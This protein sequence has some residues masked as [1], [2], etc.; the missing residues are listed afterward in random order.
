MTARVL[1][2]SVIA[3]SALIFGAAIAN[4]QTNPPTTQSPAA[5]PA[6]PPT[7]AAPP[8]H[9]SSATTPTTR[10]P[11][12]ATSPSQSSERSATPGQPGRAEP[13]TTTQ[14]TSTRN[15][16]PSGAGSG[17][18]SQTAAPST[19]S[20]SHAAT[21]PAVNL[22]TQQRTEIRNTVINTGSAPRVASVNFN[23][24]VGVV[25]PTT[26]HF[27][28]VPEALVRI[29]PAW[30]GFDYFVYADEIIIV[31]PRTRRIIAVLA[32]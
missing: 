17:S 9:S 13:G 6:N 28:P 21:A 10:E 27:A 7:S 3:L 30:R 31:D 23:V 5:S 12:R 22:T 26:V 29:E 14:G 8:A 24:A 20:P 1:S 11:G 2:T 18:S 25:V 4:G 16:T 19:S 15:P 32:V